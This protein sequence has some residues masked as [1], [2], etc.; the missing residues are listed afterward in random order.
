MSFIS[1]QVLLTNTYKN[2]RLRAVFLN[3]SNQVCTNIY[4]SIDIIR[5]LFIHCSNFLTGF[6]ESYESSLTSNAYK[7][8]EQRKNHIGTLE[9][10][11]KDAHDLELASKVLHTLQIHSRPLKTMPQTENS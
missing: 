1:L 2:V 10:L 11:L 3:I 6:K 8:L 5:T 7:P 9:H 4:N